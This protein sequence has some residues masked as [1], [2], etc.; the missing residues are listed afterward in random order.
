MVADAPR[1]R[2]RFVLRGRG[3]GPARTARRS[4]C[5]PGPYT[6]AD[7]NQASAFVTEA[8]AALMYL[9]CDIQAQYA[10]VGNRWF[11]PWT[12]SLRAT[13]HGNS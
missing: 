9:G 7:A 1:S 10:R 8:V 5:G 11:P 13:A 6:F 12:P 4:S 2:P 3:R